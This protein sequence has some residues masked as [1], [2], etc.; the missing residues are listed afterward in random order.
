MS[1]SAWMFSTSLAIN[2]INIS[3][4]KIIEIEYMIETYKF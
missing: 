2:D 1:V 4:N 3:Q